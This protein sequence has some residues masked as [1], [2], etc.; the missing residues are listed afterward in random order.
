MNS[1]NINQGSFNGLDFSFKTSSGDNISFSMYDNKELSAQS[2][3]SGN[4]SSQSY[5]LT[6]AYGYHF[7]YDGNGIDENDQKEINKALEE[8]QPKID[9]FM[10]NVNESG[11]PSPKSILNTSRDFADMMPKADDLNVLEYQKESLLDKFDLTLEKFAPNEDV[12]KGAKSLFDRIMEQ[13]ESYS[14]YA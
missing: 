13:L 6:H 2:V 11:I 3:N 7:H 5:S 10:Q 4:S 14:Y 8:L 1:T 9:E 12:L